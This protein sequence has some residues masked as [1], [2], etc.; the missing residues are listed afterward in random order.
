MKAQRRGKTRV[1]RDTKSFGAAPNAISRFLQSLGFGDK[2]L[3]S[4]GTPGKCG[5]GGAQSVSICKSRS[6][7][8]ISISSSVSLAQSSSDKCHFVPADFSFNEGTF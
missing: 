5:D 4:G 2:P 3:H 1:Q 8:R 7:R 6:D